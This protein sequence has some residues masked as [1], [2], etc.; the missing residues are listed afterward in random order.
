MRE[1]GILL[2]TDFRGSRQSKVDG[3][4]SEMWAQIEPALI[5]AQS[6]LD[7]FNRSLS[8]RRSAAL[9]DIDA[10]FEQ[11]RT[12]FSNILRERYGPSGQADARPTTLQGAAHDREAEENNS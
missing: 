8:R 2:L 1:E 6:Q 7:A 3:A 5:E 12:F 11:D 4:G 10:V 9:V